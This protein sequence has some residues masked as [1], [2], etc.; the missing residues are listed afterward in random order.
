MPG[1]CSV[2]GRVSPSL[3]LQQSSANTKEEWEK[4]VRACLLNTM[5]TAQLNLHQLWL[6]AL[7][8]IGQ[9]SKAH[10]EKG[11]HNFTHY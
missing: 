4:S 9:D 3:N 11:S 8:F 2:P 10:V 6:P 5:L 1:E 7:D